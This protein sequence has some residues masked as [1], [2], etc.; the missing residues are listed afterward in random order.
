MAR[1]IELKFEV[2]AGAG[3]GIAGAG[4]LDG[5][6]PRRARHKTVYYDTPTGTLRRRG[7]TLRIRSTGKSWVQTIKYRTGSPAGLFDREEWETKVSEPKI[8]FAA[9]A[10]TPLGQWMTTG[11]R[12][13]LKPVLETAF[14]RTTWRL[15]SGPSRIEITLDI[16][17]ISAGAMT[18]PL[19]EIEIE[20]RKG[21]T[22]P[23]FELAE[24]IARVVPLRLGVL[25]KAERGFNIVEGR[26][27]RASKAESLHLRPDMATADA[28]SAT[29]HSCLRH[30]RLNEP[31]VL[32]G[33]DAAALHQAR[34][35]IRRLRAALALFRGI[36]GDREFATL[37][38]ELRWLAGILGGARNIDVLLARLPAEEG[39]GKAVK[40]LKRSR[41]TAYDDV[42]AA[43][44]SPRCRR[45]M[46]NLVRWIE[47]GGWRAKPRAARK[48]ESYASDQ[49][50][51]RWRKLRNM[52]SRLGTLET[53][54]LHDLRIDI[55]KLRYSAEFLR[56]VYPQGDAAAKMA[57]FIAAL[58]E[59][60]DRLGE[61][62]D[63]AMAAEMSGDLRLAPGTEG[64]VAESREGNLAAAADAHRRLSAAAGYWR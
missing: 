49:L 20:L 3:D 56:G 5:A 52:G 48:L 8:D 24:Q 13:K 55:K 58:K 38:E 43:L 19:A 32:A 41:E 15:Q 63:E 35:A 6:K 44:D 16:G 22:G 57:D 54:Q 33:R 29:A 50:G 27:E 9:A 51:Q 2:D 39:K 10:Q 23:L 61:V 14:E 47:T 45:L 53:P 62:N 31:L 30:F 59:L 21:D 7:F 18:V 36:V 25:S 34:V 12:R 64:D 4:F 17:E 42:V 40:K 60:Q 28:F 46:L 1:E 11:V 26:F 37:R